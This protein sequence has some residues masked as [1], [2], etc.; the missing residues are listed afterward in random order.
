M[1]HY[2]AKYFEVKGKLFRLDTRVYLVPKKY[3]EDED[4]CIGAI[5]GKNPGSAMPEVKND[6]KTFVPID[7]NGDKLLPTVKNIMI[8]SRDKFRTS[9][10]I[11]VLNTFYLCDPNLEKAITSYTSL[12]ANIRC[13]SEK[14]R[15]PWMW[16]VW[17]QSDIRLREL[18]ER[19][20]ACKAD[21]YFFFDNTD[22]KMKMGRPQPLQPARHTQ[23]LNHE[24]V[25]PFL[26]KIFKY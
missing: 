10:Y 6:A 22:K 20:Y 1:N 2:W 16:F 14:R 12:D 7:L 5:V 8:K 21:K 9:E 26:Q 3:P 17:G 15:F 24:Y 23:G 19:F 25:L 18:K 13:E 4:K 11:Q